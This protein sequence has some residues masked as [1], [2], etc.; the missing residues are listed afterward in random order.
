MNTILITVLTETAKVTLL[1]LVMMVIVDL[2]NVWTRG[3]IAAVLKRGRQWRQYVV[4]SLI[5]AAPG[6]IGA[7]TNVSLYIHGMISFGALVG[8][9][10]AVS[11]DEAF[12]M[13]ALFPKTALLLFALLF[14]TGIAVGW[15]TDH[16]VKQWKIRTC[17]DCSSD[18][19]HPR[20]ESVSHY[21]KEHVWGHII[22]RHLWKTALWTF[23]ALLLVEIGLKQWNLSAIV[24][25][26]TL[27]LLFLGALIGLI[28]ES[29]PHL[30]FV[31]MFASGLIPFSVLFTSSFVQ[32]GHGMLLMLSYSIKDSM[33]IKGFN[34]AFGL[35]IGLVLYAVGW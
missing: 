31:T 25:E 30:V 2:V 17:A 19:L 5:G 26:Y 1:V 3:R 18:L 21:I 34:L 15:A 29:G 32:D 33:L 23:G 8:A 9:M 24:S 27:W 4:A 7:F 35:I 6:C 14:V 13:L 28:P 20:Q 10:A 11:G 22:R 16:L 12:V